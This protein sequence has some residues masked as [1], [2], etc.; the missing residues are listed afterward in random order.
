MLGK[1]KTP[2]AGF[3]FRLQD[4][5]E[6]LWVR[7]KRPELS[8]LIPIFAIMSLSFWLTF[9]WSS[10]LPGMITHLNSA[11]YDSD[12]N[13]QV[14]L[15]GIRIAMALALLAASTFCLLAF[16][17]DK[18]WRE[19]HPGSGFQD[20][21]WISILWIALPLIPFILSELLLSTRSEESIAA[22]AGVAAG[23]FGCGFIFAIAVFIG[24]WVLRLSP[25]PYALQ[26]TI[27]I[28]TFLACG[29]WIIVS[30]FRI[31]T[32]SWG[33]FFL[34]AGATLICMAWG[35][36][37]LESAEYKLDR[38]NEQRKGQAAIDIFEPV[39]EAQHHLAS[40]AGCLILN[41]S[42]HPQ[43]G[44][45]SSLDPPPA[46]WPCEKKFA[47]NAVKD[48]TL[49]YAPQADPASGRVADFHLIAVPVKKGIRGR[50]ALMVDRRGIVFSD[51]MWGISSSY[52]R[53]ATSEGRAS[54]I[55]E[56]RSNIAYYMKQQGLAAAPLTLNAE[57]IGT[58]YGF[59]V[60][61]IED[62]G[63]RLEIKNYVFSYLA[64]RAGNPSRF[65]LSMQCESYGQNCLRSYFL[66]YD[67]VVHATGEPRQATA[68]DP[69]AL[70]CEE[71]DSSCK[72]VVWPVP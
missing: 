31:G 62:N 43:A 63:T 68:D 15:H 34:A 70:E 22:G 49:S 59:Q 37:S 18:H 30:A 28:V 6:L 67:G 61:S 46:N 14:P 11:L 9:I 38:Q 32:V 3:R 47:A 33:V 16:I 56:L 39:V 35:H 1:P 55:E 10:S 36:R 5:K 64:P 42:T 69:P 17:G 8:W 26:N 25:D 40:L 71:S 50:Y 54:E 52:I 20:P 51:A 66:D 53:A 24:S 4:S 12:G 27:S 19:N 58:T 65:A 72:D 57:A 45:P 21:L 13:R 2:N 41:D 29:V 48:Y 7:S 23:L 60:P 44:Y